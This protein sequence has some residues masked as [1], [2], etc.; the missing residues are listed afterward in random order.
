[1]SHFYHPHVKVA[2]AFR[3]SEIA[4][5]DPIGFT[6]KSGNRWVITTCPFCAT[7]GHATTILV[8]AVFTPFA[9]AWVEAD[10]AAAVVLR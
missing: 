1:V 7:N 6:A 5:F 2:N 4:L 8:R 9:K 3:R 10:F